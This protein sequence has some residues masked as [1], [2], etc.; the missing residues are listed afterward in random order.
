MKK[1]VL[2]LMILGLI[3]ACSRDDNPN[4]QPAPENRAPVASAGGDQQEEIGST[5]DLDA[6]SSSDADGDVLTYKWT[7]AEKPETSDAVIMGALDA[8]AEFV[9][10]RAGTYIINLEVNDGKLT[11]SANVTIT[12][13]APEL[14]N[15]VADLPVNG[16][17][18]D[19]IVHRGG[20]IAVIGKFFSTLAEENV[21]TLGGIPCTNVTV[22][23]TAKNSITKINDK[24]E[25]MVPEEAVGGDLVVTVGPH[26]V[27][28]SEPIKILGLPI[29]RTIEANPQWTEQ[30]RSQYDPN[31]NYFEIGTRFK[32]SVSGDLLGFRI[33]MPENIQE[34]PVTL[35]DVESMQPLAQTSDVYTGD[36]AFANILLNESLPLEKDREYI[37]SITSPGNWYLHID[38]S[39]F[40]GDRFPQTYENVQ[41]LEV[42]Y[43]EGSGRDFP[44]SGQ[45]NYIMGSVDIIFVED[46]ESE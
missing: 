16:L 14:E 9:L 21:V 17:D 6:S 44:D 34:V 13:K 1:Y 46:I 36:G 15:V 30:L 40:S 4:P 7:F 8:R 42:V 10:D 3:I 23:S 43:N 28:W 41:L 32:P 31:G 5:V 27:T 11:S 37:V 18:I 2:S 35:W 33:R 20:Q 38:E 39:D 26:S 29:S 45:F 25:I 24:L 19:R 12:N 22:G